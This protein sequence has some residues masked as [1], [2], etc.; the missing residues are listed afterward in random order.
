MCLWFQLHRYIRETGTVLRASYNRLFQT[1]PN[2]NLLISNSE[3]AS[4][5]VASNARQALGGALVRIRP[6]RQ[7]AFEVGMQQALANRASL[8]IA[9]HHKRSRDQQDNDNFFNT[10]IIFPI[11]LSRLRVNGLE[12]RL[13]TLPVHGVSGMLSLTHSRAV[14][15]P[16]AA[17]SSA[18]APWTCSTPGL[19]LLITIKSSARRPP[20]ATRRGEASGRTSSRVTTPAW[21]RIRRIRPWWRAMPTIPTC[22]LT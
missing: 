16:P 3:E 5:L 22:C 12:A 1:P 18:T 8:N 13:T 2:E 14:V 20:C 17:C 19:S 21:W 10:G 15:T 7:D 4:V 11:S 6:E 9:Y